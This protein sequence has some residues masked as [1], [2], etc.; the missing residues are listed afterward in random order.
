MPS[1]S[2]RPAPRWASARACC[3]TGACGS[4]R[5]LRGCS[6]RSCTARCTYSS[7]GACWCTAPAPSTQVGRG[8]A[9]WLLALREGS[10]M[11]AQHRTRALHWHGLGVGC[12]RSLTPIL[13]CP[14]SPSPPTPCPRPRDRVCS[15][16][17]E[18]G[19]RALRARPLA[20][21][22]AARARAPHARRPG[23]RGPGVAQPRGG[24]A[25]SAVGPRCWAGRHHRVL[26]GA[27]PQDGV[28]AVRGAAPQAAGP[29]GLAPP[30]P[31]LAGPARSANARARAWLCTIHDGPMNYSAA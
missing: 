26:R 6:A 30:L 24:R 16:R 3:T 2:T 15:A 8:A 23:A 9:R 19:Q 13:G 7:R 18:R 1:C 20:R 28:D 21:R 27:P 10:A 25:R 14:S 11:G 29:A 22:A 4:S 12:H 17:R 5:T 31:R